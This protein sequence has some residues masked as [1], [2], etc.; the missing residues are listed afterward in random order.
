MITSITCTEIPTPKDTDP[1]SRFVIDNGQ[2]Q[3]M[4]TVDAILQCLCIAEIQAN[5]PP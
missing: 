3:T 5:I 2:M 4:I 1:A